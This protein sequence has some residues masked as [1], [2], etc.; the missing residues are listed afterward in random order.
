M[1]RLG[2]E[3]VLE[4]GCCVGLSHWRGSSD[5]TD[6][7]LCREVRSIVFDVGGGAFWGL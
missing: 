1:R 4:G 7:G 3:R 5:G 2:E 6:C